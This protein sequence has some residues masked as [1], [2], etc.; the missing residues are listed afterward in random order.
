M[1]TVQFTIPFSSWRRALRRKPKRVHIPPADHDETPAL[2][3]GPLDPSVVSDA[4]PAFFIGRNRAGF[5]VAREAK[6]R[7]GGLFLFKSSAISFA[8]AQGGPA[9]C[10]TI[11]PAE[12]FELDLENNGNPFAAQLAPPVRLAMTLSERMEKL[13]RALTL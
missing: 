1:T 3:F 4:I 11:F 5:W 2:Q 13:F 12:A 6:G 7:I 10:A 8:H 9:G